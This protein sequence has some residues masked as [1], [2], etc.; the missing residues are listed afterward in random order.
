MRGL[1]EK[2]DSKFR[3]VLLAANRAE[4]LMHGAPPKVDPGKR[5]ITRV[6]MDEIMDDVV[7][8]DY[9]LPPEPIEELPEE[10][11]DD[12]ETAVEATE[13]TEVTEATEEGEAVQAADTS[14]D[15]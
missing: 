14:A 2:I 13:V 10:A 7:Q 3:Y 12:L 1:P 8:W 15:A 11:M 6:A 5:K 4:Q 9:G